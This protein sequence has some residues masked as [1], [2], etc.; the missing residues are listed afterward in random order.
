MRVPHRENTD[1]APPP[2]KHH[3]Q[4]SFMEPPFFELFADT[5]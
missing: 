1:C 4:R 5:A 2:L 3:S